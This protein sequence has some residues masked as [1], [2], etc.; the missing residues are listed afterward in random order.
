MEKQLDNRELMEQGIASHAY[1]QAEAK[2]YSLNNSY[3]N[4]AEKQ[5]VELWYQLPGKI[6]D[7][8]FVLL[9]V[10]SVYKPLSWSEI[11][12]I[13]LLVN[14]IIGIWNWYFYKKNLVYK[15]YLTFLH[16]WVLYIVS[17]GAA[18]FLFF[19]GAIILAIIS[20]IVPF[21]LLSLF[22]PSMFFYAILAQRR[23]RMHPKFA[24]FKKEYGHTFP[25]EQDSASI[26]RFHNPKKDKPIIMPR[27][28]DVDGVLVKV[29]SDGKE[30]FGE[31]V[32]GAPYPPIKAIDRGEEIYE[33][34]FKLRAEAA[35]EERRE[36]SKKMAQKFVDN[37]NKNVKA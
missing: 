16:G 11:L 3:L 13:P 22:D 1:N 21:G 34:E 31:T 30:V 24:F 18:A 32:H 35:S 20:L 9:A 25:F 15:L 6:M 8:A 17:L 12:G 10:Y 27:F 28:F 2:I 23:Y 33:E 5:E 14:L 19:K 37:L 36:A 26:G 29:D 7:W 4:Y